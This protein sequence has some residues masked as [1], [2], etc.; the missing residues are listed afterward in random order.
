MA[1]PDRQCAT[2]G[3]QLSRYNPDRHCGACSVTARATATTFPFVPPA[4]WL[5]DQVRQ[6]LGAWDWS[7]VLPA[8][9]EHTG[10]SQIQIAAATGLSQAHVSRLATGA[11][12]CFDIRTAR[13]IIEGLGIPSAL[14][15]LTPP[16]LGT[17]EASTTN[18]Y[19]SAD[20]GQDEEPE[21][22]RRT[23]LA[24]SAAAPF[25]AI[26]AGASTQANLESARRVRS[27]VGDL[28][29]LDDQYGGDIVGEVASWCARRVDQILNTTDLAEAAGRELRIAYGE[30]AEMSGWLNFDAGRYEQA[31][32][33]YGE[34][35]QA[36]QLTDDLNLE[37]LVLASMNTLA[38]YR[39]RPREA[40]QLAQLAQRRAAG[41][42]PPRLLALLASREAVCWAQ[43]GD[44]GS[45]QAAM[46]RARHVFT[47]A[48]RPEDPPWIAFFDDAELAA[49]R[50]TAAGYL[51]Q[52]D[53]RIDQMR[54]AVD[55]LGP[56]YQ[57]NR[58]YY[59]VRLG[60][61][62][63]DLG[64]ETGACQTVAPVLPLLTTVRSGRAHAR[65]TEFHTRLR[66][67]G[68][69]PARDLL[70]QAHALRLVGQAV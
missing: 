52:R 58:A 70:D 17:V 1:D 8:V 53:Q 24:A 61:S 56:S 43:L 16:G 14:A 62:Q 28:Y 13:R 49:R 47:P 60:L 65:F 69:R 33:A 32:M 4:V 23:V 55:Q 66:R 21:M 38:R 7:I 64:D 51:G 31:R 48:I 63:L 46:R 50:A 25:A 11:C 36:A 22:R 9:I 10:A 40:I 29:R 19:G 26:L 45:S 34:A 39:G 2:C 12:D 41:W 27:I 3:R 68:S 6:A 5:D 30:L 54:S 44:P 35:L 42:G 67:N 15:G 59:S 57:R 18:S 20:A 37:V